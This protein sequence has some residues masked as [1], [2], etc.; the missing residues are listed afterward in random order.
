MFIDSHVVSDD[1]RG[2]LV[3][4]LFIWTVEE[5]NVYCA[6][7]VITEGTKSDGGRVAA[8]IAPDGGGRPV[9]NNRMTAV[10]PPT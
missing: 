5:G 8:G 9:E 7:A 4:V 10:K 2:V 3:S 1:G 6:A